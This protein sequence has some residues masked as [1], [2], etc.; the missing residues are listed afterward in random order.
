MLFPRCA[1]HVQCEQ[2]DAAIGPADRV[3]ALELAE[4]PVDCLTRS[5]N[6]GREVLL[7][8]FQLDHD[9]VRLLPAEVLGQLQQHARHAAVHGAR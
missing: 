4:A 7:I 6:E 3:R 2:H 9:A 5:T 1:E 8:Q